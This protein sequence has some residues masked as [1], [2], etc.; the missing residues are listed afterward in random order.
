MIAG[1][2]FGCAGGD[3]FAA[4]VAAFGAEVDEPVGGFDDVEIVFDDQKRGAGFQEFAEGREEF[5][6][7]VEMEAS[8][9]LVEDI[10]DA[11]VFGAG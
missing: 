6:D 11:L 10:E 1:Y 9:G 8:G 5:R 2:L 7:V 3:D 4:L